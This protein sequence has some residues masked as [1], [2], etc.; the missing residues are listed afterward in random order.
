MGRTWSPR[1]QVTTCQFCGSGLGDRQVGTV[2]N[3]LGT[4]G[5]S[6]S[7]VIQFPGATEKAVLGPGH[8]VQHQG[9]Q[10]CE[11]WLLG[12]TAWAVV[13]LWDPTWGE[14]LDPV[15]SFVV[16][17]LF[18]GFPW[19]KTRPKFICVYIHLPDKGTGNPLH[20]S[21]L[22]NPMDRGA[23][24]ATVHWIARVGHDL[25][26]KLPA[27]IYIHIFSLTLQLE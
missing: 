24:Q 3:A 21:C 20:C 7:S 19:N 14:I 9:S 2:Q 17:R 27:Y 18:C 23:W 8:S 10:W 16:L 1:R 15:L 11:H 6:G 5:R 4:G 12:L 13:P 26:T 25:V 22:E